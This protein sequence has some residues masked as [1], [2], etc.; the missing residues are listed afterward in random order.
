M[1]RGIERSGL[2]VRRESGVERRKWA[3]AVEGRGLSGR[4]CICAS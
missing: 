2:V 4:L 1:R 3:E